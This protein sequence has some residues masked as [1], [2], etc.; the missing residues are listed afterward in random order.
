MFKP[1][2]ARISALEAAIRA[3]LGDPDW[4]EMVRVTPDG[5]ASLILR[6]DPN[7]M[8]SAENLRMEVESKVRAIK[9]IY[10]VNAALTAERPQGEQTPQKAPSRSSLQTTRRVRKGARLSDEALS[11]GAPAASATI[12]PIT[13]IKAILA[14]SS[15]KGGVGKSTVAVNLA[16]ALASKGL[17]IGLLDADI[18]GPSVPT[19]L[20]TTDADPRA[21][22]DKKL[23]PI[24]AH[25]LKS[26]FP[27]VT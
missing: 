24:E 23:L 14:I 15:A 3:A 17:S 13:G 11:Q 8:A 26:L 1:K 9:G 4:V 16:V 25:G 12:S 19:M 27:L 7:D 2:A 20:G 18:Y 5:K 10:E 22:G 21:G 6:G